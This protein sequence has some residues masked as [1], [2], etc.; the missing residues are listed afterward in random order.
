VALI[1]SEFLFE[2]EENEDKDVFSIRG[3]R[4]QAREYEGVYT[5]EV[6]KQKKENEQGTEI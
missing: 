4:Y 6:F 5:I 1:F 3:K 2:E